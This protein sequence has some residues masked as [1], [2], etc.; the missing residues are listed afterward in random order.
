[1]C[2]TVS[3]CFYTIVLH[4]YV[5]CFVVSSHLSYIFHKQIINSH[6]MYVCIILFIAVNGG[7]SSWTYG[8][9]SKTCGGGEQWRTRKCWNPP[10][11]CG[12]KNCTGL[13]NERIKCNTSCCRGKN[14][15]NLYMYVHKYYNLNK[16]HCISIK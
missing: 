16:K 14:M 2:F 9:C 6:V 3:V 5:T 7:W 8:P 4:I 10:P 13:S 15:T 12:G 1:M 11:S